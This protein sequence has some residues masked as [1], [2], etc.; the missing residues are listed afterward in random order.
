VDSGQIAALVGTGMGAALASFVATIYAVGKPVKAR[1]EELESTSL[2]KNQIQEL[3][4]RFDEKHSE[5]DKRLQALAESS[6][7]LKEKC[8]SLETDSRQNATRIDEIK[9][10]MVTLVSSEEFQTHAGY[11]AQSLNALTDKVGRA[12]GALEAWRERGR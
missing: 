3:E 12:I 4:N 1:V 10:R 8:E 9:D 7:V 6:A 11:T 5:L 2:K